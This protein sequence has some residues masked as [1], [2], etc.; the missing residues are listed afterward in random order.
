MPKTL[1][2]IEISK[3]L[4]ELRNITLLHAKARKRVEKL[5][6]TLAITNALLLVK[7]QRIAELEAALEDKEL[8]RKTM[9]SYLYKAEKHRSNQTERQP[10]KQLGAKGYHR[11]T[12]K[13]DTVTERAIF[14]LVRCPMCNSQVGE[15]VDEVQKYQEDIDLRP[16][17]IVKHYTVSRHWCGKCETYVKSMNTPAHKLQRIGPHVMGYVLYARYRLRL[18][19]LKVKESLNDLYGFK[20]SEGEVQAQLAEARELFGERYEAICE[21]IR[22]AKVVYADETGWRMD[23]RNW[24]LWVFVSP[25][26]LRYTIEDTRGGRVAQAALGK[27]TDRV[28]ISDGYAVYPKLPGDNQQCWVHL[29]RVAKLASRKLYEDLAVLYGQLLQALELPT[30]QRDPPR[31]TTELDRIASHTYVESTARKVQNRVTKHRDLLLTCLRYEAVLPENNTAERAI[32]PQVIM[33]KIFGGSRSPAGAEIHAINTSVIATELR[34]NSDT[35]ASFFE[36]M[37]PLLTRDGE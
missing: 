17:K 4:Q 33:R 11:P 10:G 26:G 6:A 31:F 13:P 30:S 24:Y 32:R 23:G 20:I 25:Q 7:D 3:R 28:I 9:A 14:N 36:L 8:Q 16:R 21:A 12:P 1:D 22:S 5:E 2:K 18:P 27:K 15:A 29:L 35:N 34:K 37:L 19:L